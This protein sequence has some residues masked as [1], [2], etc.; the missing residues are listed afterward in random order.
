M[1]NHPAV[2][3]ARELV[4]T[5]TRVFKYSMF[6]LVPLQADELAILNPNLLLEEAQR[7]SS[8]PYVEIINEIINAEIKN[9][10]HAVERAVNKLLKQAYHSGSLP[11]NK[12]ILKAVIQPND[13]KVLTEEYNLEKCLDE[14]YGSKTLQQ[15]LD[16]VKAAHRTNMQ[17]KQA[18]EHL[19]QQRLQKKSQQTSKKKFTIMIPA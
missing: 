13:Y 8:K 10:D 15:I 18:E 4:N 1:Q 5:R 11:S 3:F 19:K 14:L 6:S 17:I 2:R 9:T 16:E 12:Q 7:P